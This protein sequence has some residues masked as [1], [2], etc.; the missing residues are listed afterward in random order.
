MTVYETIL[1]F[2]CKKSRS[3]IIIQLLQT[4]PLAFAPNTTKC[5][6][7]QSTLSKQFGNTP[8][9]L[10]KS[11]PFVSTQA[12][13]LFVWL[14]SFRRS[15]VPGLALCTVGRRR[16]QVCCARSKQFRAVLGT[17]TI[18]Q[19]TRCKHLFPPLGP[20]ELQ[21]EAAYCLACIVK[22][23]SRSILTSALYRL[24]HICS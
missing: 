15:A 16:Y 3:A 7:F 9:C 20:M 14:V 18:F 13:V 19:E 24:P 21:A 17:L 12:Q 4:L 10:I 8:T 11:A 5:Y 6:D 1:N 2:Y 23:L 22:H